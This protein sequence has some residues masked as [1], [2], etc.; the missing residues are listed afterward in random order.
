MPRAIYTSDITREQFEVIRPQ[1]DNFKK[2]QETTKPRALD[3][4]DVFCAVVYVLKSC[5]QWRMPLSDYPKWGCSVHV[6][7]S[8]SF[9]SM[10]YDFLTKMMNFMALAEASC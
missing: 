9:L 7:K 8:Q 5:C 3:I 6:W 10:G 2:P 4:Y 1:L